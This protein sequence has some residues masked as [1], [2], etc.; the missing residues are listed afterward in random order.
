[1]SLLVNYYFYVFQLTPSKNVEAILGDIKED[2]DI[3]VDSQSSCITDNIIDKNVSAVTRQSIKR[4]KN[5]SGRITKK[6]SKIDTSLDNVVDIL[7]LAF[8]QKATSNEFTIFG[9]HVAAQLEKLPLHQAVEL[10]E[11][12]QSILTKARL[13]NL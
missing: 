8:K 6:I 9:N 7:K 4:N 13:N 1:M 2:P 12:I 10:Q 3:V 5:K 11:Q